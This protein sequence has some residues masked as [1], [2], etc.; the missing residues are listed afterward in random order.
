MIQDQEY[1]DLP[2]S[3]QVFS[4]KRLVIVEDNQILMRVIAKR[5]AK[6][7]GFICFQDGTGEH[8]IKL[9]KQHQPD[10]IL[11][12]MGLPLISGLSLIRM[13]RNEAELENVPIIVYSAYGFSDLVAEALDSGA[14]DYFTKSKPLSELFNL[15]EYHLS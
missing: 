14:N 12:D 7:Y 5:A 4:G 6:K 10:L 8:C 9:C 3:A 11:M 13:I 2:K 15:I 1:T